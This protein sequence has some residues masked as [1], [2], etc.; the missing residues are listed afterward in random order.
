VTS[1]L[2]QNKRL[3]LDRQARTEPKQVGNF[4]LLENRKRKHRPKARN[5]SR[6]SV[7]SS[8][9]C[10]LFAPLLATFCLQSFRL[11]IARPILVC[12]VPSS[13]NHSFY[14]RKSHT[15]RLLILKIWVGGEAVVVDG[16]LRRFA[17]KEGAVSW[18]PSEPY[19]LPRESEAS[20]TNLCIRL[21]VIGYE[22]R[23]AKT[24]PTYV[25][26]PRYVLS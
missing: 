24:P 10:T 14:R 4:G 18:H 21:T 17:R 25:I 11:P 16:W 5:S 7:L 19:C 15:A 20:L 9:G 22:L 8:G 2:S 1:R 6:F 26:R 12:V 23:A 3:P 13:S